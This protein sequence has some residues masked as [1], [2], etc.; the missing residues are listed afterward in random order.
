MIDEK[1]KTISNGYQQ[2]D[3]LIEEYNEGKLSLKP[4]CDAIQT[5]EAEI[6]EK[7]N[8]LREEAGDVRILPPFIFRSLRECAWWKLLGYVNCLTNRVTFSPILS[9]IAVWGA[10]S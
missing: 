2:C 7:L 8:K 1:G 9:S 10:H 4:G 3:K 5:L 6:T